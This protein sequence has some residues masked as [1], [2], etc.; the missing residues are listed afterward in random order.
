MSRRHHRAIFRSGQ[1]YLFQRF[2]GQIGVK[3]S[4]KENALRPQR[5][6][7]VV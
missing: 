3:G 5:E 1:R 7:G 6:G 4:V 2:G